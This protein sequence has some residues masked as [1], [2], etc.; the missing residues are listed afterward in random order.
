MEKLYPFGVRISSGSGHKV[1]DSRFFYLTVGVLTWPALSGLSLFLGSS[2]PSFFLYSFIF[3]WPDVFH[4]LLPPNF[5]T[6]LCLF[7]EFPATYPTGVMGSEVGVSPDSKPQAVING[8]TIWWAVW[9]CVWTTAVVSG[10][11]Y[12]I[13]NRNAPTLR[14]RGIF[15][16]L[17][18]IVLLHLYW[19]SVQ[20]GVMVGPLMPGDAEYWIMGTYLPCGIALFHASNSRFLHVAKHQKKYAY[21]DSGFAHTAQNSKHKSGLIARFRNLDYNIRI[22]IAVG[23]AMVLQ[24]R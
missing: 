1:T 23:T 19:I 16:S 14:V 10:M 11:A 13:V 20:F 5:V 12:L 4:C 21:R 7:L 24:V 9:A 8:V 18:A 3:I 17:S 15:L 6:F 2:Y 22:L